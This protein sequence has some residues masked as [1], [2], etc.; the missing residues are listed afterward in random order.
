[1]LPGTE[2]ETATQVRHF[3][4]RPREAHATLLILVDPVVVLEFFD[5][6]VII[7]IISKRK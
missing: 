5:D 1:M 2:G 4:L 3:A 7:Q 6:A